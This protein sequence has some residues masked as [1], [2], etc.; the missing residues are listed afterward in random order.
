MPDDQRGQVPKAFVQLAD[1]YEPSDD[2]AEELQQYVKD[3]LAKYEYPRQLEFID[4]LPTTATGKIRRATLK[5]QGNA[6]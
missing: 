5:S 6:E 3:R 1:G 4:Q 2:L